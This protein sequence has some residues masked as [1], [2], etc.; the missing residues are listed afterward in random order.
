MG[1]AIS[2]TMLRAIGG[3]LWAENN[4]GAGAAF[5]FTVPVASA[6]DA[7]MAST[8]EHGHKETK[9][10]AARIFIVDDDPSVLKAMDRLIS[11]AGYT[12]ETFASAQA[13]LQREVYDGNGCL[14]ADLHMPGETGLDL[15]TTL[16]T[17][18]YTLPVIFI[19]GAGNTSAGVHAMKQGAVDFLPKPVEE[20]LLLAAIE[21][22]VETDRQAR[23]RY[24]QQ[25]AAKEKFA[26]LTP[27]ELEIMSLV[28][29]GKLNKQIAHTLGISEK[30]VKTHRGSVMRKA[31]VRSVADLVRF[32]ELVADSQ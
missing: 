25:V 6:D 11:S 12:V 31:E 8:Q 26:R 27:R 16:N 24:R 14:L 10:E 7:E 2:N 15:Q 29:K 1:L 5:Y 19:T 32:S 18:D 3:R 21:R 30:T 9:A 20:E 28:V 17:R 4:P 22:A 23:G 13:F